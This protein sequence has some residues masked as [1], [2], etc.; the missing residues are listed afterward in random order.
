MTTKHY[1]ESREQ[2]LELR[3]ALNKEGKFGGSDMGAITGLSHW[4]SPYAIWAELTGRIEVNEDSFSPQAKERMRQGRDLEAYVADRFCEITG[5]RVHQINA[6]ITSD[7]H[8]YLFA[9][10]DRK[11]N[12]EDAGLEC[13]RMSDQRASNLTNDS[14]PP[15]YYAQCV[16]YLAATELTTW[17]LCIM[18]NDAIRIY[19]ITR[20]KGLQNPEWSCSVHYVPDEEITALDEA[21]AWMHNLIESDTP[22]SVDG[23]DS[24]ADTIAEQY[25]GDDTVACNLDATPIEEILQERA[26]LKAQADEIKSKL[27]ECENNIKVFL[28]QAEGAFTATYKVTWKPTTRKT[29]DADAIA[30]HFQGNIP[31]NFYKESTTRTLRI[32]TTKTK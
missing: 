16:H 30:A 15:E 5:K 23:S 25:P 12:N 18:S 29:L 13:K 8:P 11:I 24:T 14:M 22:P 32:T 3:N 19:T 7:Q 1:Y 28:G 26:V 2:W 21:A 10:I 20:D 6:I 4:K 9:T 17:Y 31:S 27:A